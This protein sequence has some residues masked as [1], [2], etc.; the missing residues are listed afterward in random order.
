MKQTAPIGFKEKE[1]NEKVFMFETLYRKYNKPTVM[2]TLQIGNKDYFELLDYMRARHVVSVR[3][4]SFHERTTTHYDEDDYM[5]INKDTKYI[6]TKKGVIHLD[7]IKSTRSRVP[8]LTKAIREYK[9]M[10]KR[11]V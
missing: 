9:T 2:A 4:C 10:L 11:A 8:E 7:E 5:P 1:W 6:I 3:D